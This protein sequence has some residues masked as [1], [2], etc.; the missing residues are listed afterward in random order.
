MKIGKKNKLNKNKITT[1][2]NN[3]K[4]GK[5]I[6][7]KKINQSDMVKKPYGGHLPFP[8]QDCAK[9]KYIFSIKISDKTVT[10]KII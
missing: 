2:K 10:E 1:H 7:E 8:P 3:M 4:I 9:R 5:K 6:K